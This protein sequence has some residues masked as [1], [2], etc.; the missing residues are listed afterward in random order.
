[1]HRAKV[2]TRV[3]KKGTVMKVVKEHYLR[4]DVVCG[5]LV[6]SVTLPRLVFSA[7]ADT[8]CAQTSYDLMTGLRDMPS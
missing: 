1:M 5:S 4:D 7:L 3:T 8:A 6:R 2:F